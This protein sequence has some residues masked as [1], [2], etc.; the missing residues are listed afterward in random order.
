MGQRKN[1]IELSYNKRLISEMV[2]IKSQKH[3]INKM[4]RIH[5]RNYILTSY[6]LFPTLS[7]LFLFSFHWAPSCSVSLFLLCCSTLFNYIFLIIFDWDVW[8]FLIEML[9]SLCTSFFWLQFAHYKMGIH[10]RLVLFFL[11]SLKVKMF[12]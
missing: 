3:G 10:K 11:L 8:L 5:C 2:Y 9:H 4:I 7:C 1:Y 6:N 12:I